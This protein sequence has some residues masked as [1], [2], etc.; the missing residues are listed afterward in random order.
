[1]TKQKY[2]RLNPVEQFKSVLTNRMMACQGVRTSGLA[3]GPRAVG[4][5]GS[6]GL[7]LAGQ[8]GLVALVGILVF[9]GQCNT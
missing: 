9:R 5:T 6:G 4:A 8:R 7:A 3:S 2:Q 1:M